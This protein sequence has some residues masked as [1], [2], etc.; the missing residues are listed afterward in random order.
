MASLSSLGARN[1]VIGGVNGVG[2]IMR[3]SAHRRLSIGVNRRQLIGARHQLGAAL[4][5]GARNQLIGV[6]ARQ[7]SARRRSCISAR[8]GA[9]ASLGGVGMSSRVSGIALSKASAA[10]GAQLVAA[11]RG[12]W[13]QSWRNV[14]ARHHRHRRS[15]LSS[16]SCAR[17]SKRSRSGSLIGGGAHRQRNRRHRHRHQRGEGALGVAAQLGVTAQ[18]AHRGAASSK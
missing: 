11:S 3:R 12:V 2:G 4:G 8:R 13:H 6:G 5:V 16:A 14:G 1:G 9:A 17:R 7:S 10:L 18:L 15:A